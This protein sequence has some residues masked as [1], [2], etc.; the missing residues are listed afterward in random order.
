M[1]FSYLVPCLFSLVLIGCGEK[2]VDKDGVPIVDLHG[3]IIV[4]QE[5]VKTDT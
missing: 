3:T 5:A 4:T 2:T 1:K